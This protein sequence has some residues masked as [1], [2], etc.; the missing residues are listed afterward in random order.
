[1]VE[2]TAVVVNGHYPDGISGHLPNGAA[3]PNG[4]NPDG[5]NGRL[6]NGTACSNGHYPD[7]IDGHL[8]NEAAYSKREVQPPMP[9]AIV[10]MACRL[11]G[12]VSDLESFWDFCHKARNAW[13]EIPMKRLNTAAFHHPNPEKPG[14]VRRILSLSS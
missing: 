10:G 8:P 13:T 4:D 3:Y 11:P 7:G 5:I 14:C 2:E 12:G 9:I 6:S 1:M